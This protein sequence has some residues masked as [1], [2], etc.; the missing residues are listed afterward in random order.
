[1]GAIFLLSLYVVWALAG[2]SATIYQSAPNWIVQIIDWRLTGLIAVI[3]AFLIA[4]P[5]AAFHVRCTYHRVQRPLF[6]NILGWI[7]LV[8]FLFLLWGIIVAWGFVTG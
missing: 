4:L 7:T 1:V 8:L 3:G 5:A 2:E 6:G